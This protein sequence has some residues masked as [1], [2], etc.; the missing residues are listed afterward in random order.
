MTDPIRVLVPNPGAMTLEGT[1]TWVLRGT[2]GEPAVVVDPGPDHLGHLATVRATCADG[3]AEIWITHGHQD[4]VGGA[5]R[6]AHW[7]DC[8]IRAYDGRLS[9]GRPLRAGV[10][11]EL[12]AGPVV[13]LELPG[14]TADS[15]GLVMST[16]TDTVM[17][18]GDTVLGRGSTQIAWPDGDL[19]HYLASLD[20]MERAVDEHVVARLLPGHG[21]VVRDPS[22][23]I[24]QY[25]AH[26][27]ARLEQ[28]RT[29]Y[30]AGHTS[31]PALVEAV[32]GDLV[33]ATRRAAELTVRAQLA[34]L[35]LPGR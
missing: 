2:P 33:G 35:G 1:N 16:G 28:V 20:A 32:Y 15:I 3:I 8:P 26:R 25:R 7:A 30:E 13:C 34:Y 23:R 4:H 22:A 17:L 12:P 27:L 31:V 10:V 9:T 19:G 11:A 29:S 6:L 18:C 14:H 5:A 24:A 21:P